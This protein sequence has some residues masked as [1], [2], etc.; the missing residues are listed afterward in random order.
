[1]KASTISQLGITIK[2]GQAIKRRKTKPLEDSSNNDMNAAMAGD[3]FVEKPI[4]LIKSNVKI[5]L[6]SLEIDAE[7]GVYSH[8]MGKKRKLILDIEIEMQKGFDVSSDDLSKTYDYDLLAKAA[9]DVAARKHY[10]LIETYAQEVGAEILKDNRIKM[11]KIRVEKPQSVAGAIASG[12][13][14]TFSR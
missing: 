10:L 1:M 2:P 12:T 9:R 3:D 6:K 13:E 7:C 5:F 4:N 14:I 8:E 11:A